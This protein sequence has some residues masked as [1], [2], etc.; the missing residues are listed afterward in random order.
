MTEYDYSPDALSRYVENQTRVSNWIHRQAYH[1]S[2]YTSPFIDPSVAGDI[3]SRSGSSYRDRERD[4]HRDRD[5]S[6][7][8]HVPAV[9]NSSA[10]PYPQQPRGASPP[11]RYQPSHH[12]SYSTHNVYQYPYQYSTPTPQVAYGASGHRSGVS[13]KTI[14]IDPNAKELY[15][16]PPRRGEQYIIIPP[17]GR[18]VQVIEHSDGSR[19]SST[20]RSRSPRSP[21]SPT[22]KDA[23]LLKR[24]FH[25]GGGNGQKLKSSGS[26]SRRERRTSF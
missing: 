12:P 24:L 16:P 8:R 25:I 9:T 4:S 11:S 26:S 20:S 2:E 5:R 15:L 21:H 19:S 14:T 22:K 23:P 18:T 6:S 10:Y 13:T 7:S 17:K 3:P 1:A